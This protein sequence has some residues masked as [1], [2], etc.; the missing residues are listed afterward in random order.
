VVKTLAILFAESLIKQE[1]YV[2]NVK[3]EKEIW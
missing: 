1:L 3:K 2:K